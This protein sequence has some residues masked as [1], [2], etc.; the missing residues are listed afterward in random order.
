M[1]TNTE[2]IA[3]MRESAEDLLALIEEVAQRLPGGGGDA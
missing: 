1:M 3:A 2:L